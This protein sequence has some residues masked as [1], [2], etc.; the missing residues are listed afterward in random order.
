MQFKILIS[1]FLSVNSIDPIPVNSIDFI[2]VKPIKS[3]S[4]SDCKVNKTTKA[5]LLKKFIKHDKH[6]LFDQDVGFGRAA[7]TKYYFDITENDCQSFIW[8]GIGGCA[9]FG[10]LEECRKACMNTDSDK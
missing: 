10:S 5:T 4:A 7:F 8:G 6:Y 2:P 9:P 3:L 1:L